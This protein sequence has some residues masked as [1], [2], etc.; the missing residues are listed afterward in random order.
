MIQLF[1]LVAAPELS[2]LRLPAALAK[3]EMAQPAVTNSTGSLVSK[4]FRRALELGSSFCKARV[5]R[6]KLRYTIDLTTNIRM[7][8]FARM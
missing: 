3:L 5:S 6:S 7:I 4:D 2:W 1:N 8:A